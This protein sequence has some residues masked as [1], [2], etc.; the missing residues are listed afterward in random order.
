MLFKFELLKQCIIEL[1]AENT[2]LRKENTVISDLKNKLSIFN[3]KRAEFKYRIAKALRITEKKRTKY[4]AKNAKLKARIKKLE[5]NKEDSLAKNIRRNVE[6]A[7]IKVKVMKLKDN[8]EKSK[9]LT[10]C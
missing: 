10:S 6:I 7:E 3:T 2:E 5:K 4:I 9:Q 1:E 8:N